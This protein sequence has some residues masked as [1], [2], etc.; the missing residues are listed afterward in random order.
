MVREK[1]WALLL[2]DIDTESKAQTHQMEGVLALCSAI[3]YIDDLGYLRGAEDS[4]ETRKMRS[5]LASAELRAAATKSRAD[6]TEHQALQA[7]SLI[8]VKVGRKL[9]ANCGTRSFVEQSST[10]DLCRKNN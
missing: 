8:N 9:F 4:I 5:G 6:L 7:V 1:L 10:T 2:G 3:R